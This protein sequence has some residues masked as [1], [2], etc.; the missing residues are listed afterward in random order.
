MRLEI[1]VF[2]P[3]FDVILK[4]GLAQQSLNLV[5]NNNLR[6]IV[7]LKNHIIQDTNNERNVK[8]HLLN[9]QFF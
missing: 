6:K 8:I 5:W 1:K 4:K 7:F 9:Q 2:K 3:F